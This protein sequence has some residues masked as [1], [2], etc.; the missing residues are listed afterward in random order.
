MHSSSDCHVVLHRYH[1]AGINPFPLSCVYKIL[2]T[3]SCL[4]NSEGY[5]YS[6]IAPQ[7]SEKSPWQRSAFAPTSRSQHPTSQLQSA[8]TEGVSLEA[9]CDH[10]I[11]PY[12]AVFFPF[13]SVCQILCTRLFSYDYDAYI[14]PYLYSLYVKCLYIKTPVTIYHIYLSIYLPTYLSIYLSIYLYLDIHVYI[15]I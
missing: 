10:L 12:P 14:A 4:Y 2:Y 11:E 5:I 1:T 9:P 7:S 15:Y 6:C 3:R 13:S 8:S